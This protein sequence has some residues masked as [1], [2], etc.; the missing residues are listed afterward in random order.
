[1][2]LTPEVVVCTYFDTKSIALP[3][4]DLDLDAVKVC[5]ICRSPWTTCGESTIA[6]TLKECVHWIKKTA[7]TLENW[8]DSLKAAGAPGFAFTLEIKDVPKP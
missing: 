6:P 8:R 2:Q 7:T 4:L 1:M 3:V 5:P